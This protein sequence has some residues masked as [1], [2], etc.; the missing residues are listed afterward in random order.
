[1]SRKVRVTRKRGKDIPI[2]DMVLADIEGMDRESAQL[3]A[4]MLLKKHAEQII[5][6]DDANKLRITVLE[7]NSR[8]IAENRRLNEEVKRLEGTEDRVTRAIRIEAYKD[9]EGTLAIRDGISGQAIRNIHRLVLHRG[10]EALT[11]TVGLPSVP[12]A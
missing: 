10:S 2:G 12:E 5:K 3:A 9:S 1:M 8:L 11:L 7:E 4:R 6:L